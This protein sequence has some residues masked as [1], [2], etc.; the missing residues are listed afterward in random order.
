MDRGEL[1]MENGERGRPSSFS[2]LHSPLVI[3]HYKKGRPFRDSLF[4][5]RVGVVLL[6]NHFN[7]HHS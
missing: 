3:R 5:D 2:I 1:R 7:L 4:I 6:S